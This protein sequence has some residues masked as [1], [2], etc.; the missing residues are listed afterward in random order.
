M[1]LF[2]HPGRV[3]VKDRALAGFCVDACATLEQEQLGCVQLLVYTNLEMLDAS[4][5]KKT[6]LMIPLCTSLLGLPFL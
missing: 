5:L 2:P 1:G 4:C 6:T 3:P